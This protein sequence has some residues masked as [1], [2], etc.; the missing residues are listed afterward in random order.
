MTM[1]GGTATT[2]REATGDGGDNSTAIT[3]F[4]W[5]ASDFCEKAVIEFVLD[6]AVAAMSQ[7]F[8]VGRFCPISIGPKTQYGYEERWQCMEQWL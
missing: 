2:R 6:T 7:T 3:H 4:S 5:N 1:P 8:D